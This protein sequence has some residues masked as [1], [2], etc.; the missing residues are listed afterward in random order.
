[1]TDLSD[2]RF[3]CKTECKTR[4][5]VGRIIRASGLQ[6]GEELAQTYW[7]EEFIQG[8]VIS[9]QLLGPCTML[10]ALVPL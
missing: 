10:G 9:T 3:D 6:G 5:A 2:H 1:M 8:R 7:E 4:E